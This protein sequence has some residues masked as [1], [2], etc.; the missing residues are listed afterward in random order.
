MYRHRGPLYFR[1]KNKSYKPWLCAYADVHNH[2]QTYPR[3]PYVQPKCCEKISKSNSGR[4]NNRAL[5]C[6]ARCASALNGACSR[7]SHHNQHTD[8]SVRSNLHAQNSNPSYIRCLFVHVFAYA[9]VVSPPV[10]ILI[11]PPSPYPTTQHHYHGRERV[12]ME[13]KYGQTASLLEKVR[14][15]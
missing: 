4:S 13:S 1:I 6:S 5:K 7:C 9:S 8:T 10:L 14:H 11:P 3:T 15:R 12:V 2:Y